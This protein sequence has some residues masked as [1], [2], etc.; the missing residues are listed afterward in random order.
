MNIPLKDINDI[1]NP[2]ME[3]VKHSNK[4]S[5]GAFFKYQVFKI[6]NAVFSGIGVAIF[7]FVVLYLLIK[8][9]LPYVLK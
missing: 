7:I 8:F 5:F 6:L 1:I 3:N 4:V 9:I 2:D